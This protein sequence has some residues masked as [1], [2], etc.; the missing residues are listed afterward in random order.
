MPGKR[1][2]Y[3]WVTS[4]LRLLAGV[5]FTRLAA[6]HGWNDH[7]VDIVALTIGVVCTYAQVRID[8]LAYARDD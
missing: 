8:R 2:L 7:K 4:P 3:A 5:K 6:S 1:R